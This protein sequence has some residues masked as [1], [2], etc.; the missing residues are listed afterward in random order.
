MIAFLKGKIILK[1]EKFI[2]LD[3]GGVGYKV[4]LSTKTISKISQDNQNPELFCFLNVRENT[5]DLYG[6]LD[7]EELELFEILND[8]SGVGPKIALEIASLGP[9]EKLKKAIEKQK[10][11][12]FE[13]IPGIGR[14]RAQAIILELSGILREISKEKLKGK[15]T[16]DEVEEAL[17]NLGFPR[18][19]AK[20]A[21]SK[22]P[23]GIKDIEQRIKE[24]LKILGK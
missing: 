21:L 8:I 6:F 14:K 20:E 3:A 16:P 13:K 18:Q 2:I 9:L 19:R 23:E 1:K 5:L 24:A 17:V 4:F 22:I 7:F 11:K 10:E 15:K 12:V